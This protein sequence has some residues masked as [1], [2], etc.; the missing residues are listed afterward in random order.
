MN[1]RSGTSE[2][3]WLLPTLLQ[4]G[5]PLRAVYLLPADDVAGGVGKV[6]V[7]AGGVEIQSP[8]VHQVLDGDHVLV[9]DFGVHVHPPD[10]AG[11]TL[12]VHQ[13]QLVIRLCGE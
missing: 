4:D 12:T 8:G 7:L 9:R 5:V 3:T 13:E 11:T 2:I 1:G 6:D 10:D